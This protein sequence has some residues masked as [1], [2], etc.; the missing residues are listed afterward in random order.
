MSWVSELG[1][2]VRGAAAARSPGGGS[3]TSA[4]GPG[5]ALGSRAR[6]SGGRYEVVEPGSFESVTRERVD[7]VGLAVS[8][9]ELKVNLIFA[10]VVSAVLA[11]IY[12]AVH[13]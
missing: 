4:P 9:I 12:R 7:Q 8:R 5:V 2:V 10:G 13:G 6:S 3:G 11:D 1:R